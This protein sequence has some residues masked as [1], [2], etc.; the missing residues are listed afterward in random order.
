MAELARALDAFLEGVKYAKQFNQIRVLAALYNSIGNLYGSTEEP[1]KALA[2]YFHSIEY[3]NKFNTKKPPVKIYTNISGVYVNLQ[4]FDSALYYINYCIDYNLKINDEFSLTSNYIGLSEV[5]VALKD[6]KNALKSAKNANN[7]AKKNDDN[8]T[9]SHTFVQLG[10]TYLLNEN[11][12]ESEEALNE[13][14]KYSKITGDMPALEL[15]TLYLSEL[16]EKVK[17]YKSAL[18]IFKEYRLYKDSALNYE[19][20][21][22][23]KNAEAK[24]ENEKKQK[25]IEILNQKQKHIDAESDNK[26]MLL[27][28]SMLGIA[29]LGIGLLFLYRNNLLKH[30][31]NLHLSSYNQE[32]NL[33]KELVE[34]KNK[35]ITDSINYAKRIQQSVLTSEV[36]FKANTNDFFIL[37]KPKDIVSGDFYWAIQYDQKFLL[38]TADC[39]NHGVP[40]AMMSMMGINFL[41]EIVNEKKISQPADILN[42]L[43]KDIIKTL[44]PEGKLYSTN[45]GLDCNLCS[46]DFKNL[47]LTY[48]NANNVFYIIRNNQLI[49]SKTNNMT[50]GVGTTNASFEQVEFELQKNDLIITFTDGYADQFGGSSGKKFKYKQFEDLLIS[51]SNLQL[52]ELK[53]ILEK[54]IDEWRGNMEQ[55]DDI[56]I[57]GIRV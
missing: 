26:K 38:M 13:A 20:I 5:Y 3:Y 29:V 11:Y 18:S 25:E 46:F 31:T 10:Y 34:M 12:K 40:G 15:S 1:R 27:Y 24:F 22:Q 44:N 9:L 42:Q 43:K 16:F 21:Q 49:T 41:N 55:V 51:H 37:F 14:I 54:A 2:N 57:V 28:A 50:V 19:S 45:D 35:E 47:K 53:A 52:S 56:C 6:F 23:V 36:Y 33:Q 39:T 4:K 7:Y 8:Y 17:D 32:I 30:K 48:S